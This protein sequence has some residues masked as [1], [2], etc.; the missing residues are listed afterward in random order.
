MNGGR[1]STAGNEMSEQ[2]AGSAAK[3]ARPP[4]KAYR[5][6]ASPTQLLRRASS[7]RHARAANRTAVAMRYDGR[8]DPAASSSRCSLTFSSSLPVSHS[9]F[10]LLSL[11]LDLKMHNRL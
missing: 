3:G 4:S 7:V 1:A 9:V 11:S 10:S 2:Q 5:D 8:R 6:D